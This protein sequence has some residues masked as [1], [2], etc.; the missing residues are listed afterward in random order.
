MLW[1]GAPLV[2]AESSRSHG[3]ALVHACA[4]CHG[5]D[6][7][8]QGA[9]PSFNT[10][11]KE[12]LVEALRA[13]RSDKRQGTVMTR[14]AKGLEDVDIEAIATYVSKNSPRP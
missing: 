8:S 6:G 4:A 11:Q 12:R 5:P 7:Q 14:I 9:I 2:L 1:L 10:L 3:A 13:F